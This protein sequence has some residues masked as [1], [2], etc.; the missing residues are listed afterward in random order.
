MF[1]EL[2]VLDMALP[3]AD[4]AAAKKLEVC[5]E[6]VLKIPSS[7]AFVEMLPSVDYWI[8][9]CSLELNGS[10]DLELPVCSQCQYQVDR[11]DKTSFQA[12]RPI[13]KPMSSFPTSFL[14]P[15]LHTHVLAYAIDNS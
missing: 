9:L 5:R 11:S 8:E 1:E 15:S 4:M 3:V 6:A 12:S 10:A 13:A 14:L 2:L 7:T